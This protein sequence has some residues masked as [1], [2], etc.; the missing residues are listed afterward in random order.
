MSQLSARS[1]SHGYH[2][3]TVLPGVDVI[4]GAGERLGLVG[5]NGAGK[6]T[7]LRLLAGCERPDGGSVI[8]HGDVGFLAQ[9]PE[10]PDGGTIGDAIDAS[11]SRFRT[12]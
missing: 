3:R 10:L 4:A 1:L 5:Q 6:S 11:L 7:L 8:R 12:L 9:E 2:G